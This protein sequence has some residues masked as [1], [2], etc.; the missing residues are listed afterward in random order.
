MH[1]CMRTSAV[2][3]L[4]LLCGCAG[5]GAPAVP[6]R[7]QTSTTAEQRE[8]V[9]AI[10][11]QADLGDVV[12]AMQALD[13]LRQKGVVEAERLRQDLLRQ[14]GRVG[15]LRREAEA[16]RTAP[17]ATV[18]DHYL[19]GR[20]SPPGAPMVDAFETAV[21]LD[22]TS[23][24]P[25]LGLAF[26]LRDV[27]PE[28]SLAIYERL[29]AGSDSQPVVAV[30]FAS[31]LRSAGKLKEALAVYERLAKGSGSEVGIGRLGMAQ[32]LFAL[33]GVQERAQAWASLLVALRERPHDPGVHALLRELLRAGIP[34][35]QLEQCLDVLRSDR[36]RWV[37]FARGAGVELL[38]AILPRLGQPQAA[39]LAIEN[40]GPDRDAPE[41]RR[42][43]RKLLLACG[44]A[45]GFQAALAAELPAEVLAS[46][47]N[48]V[49]GLW[50]TLLDTAPAGADP[51]ASPAA[52]APW[53]AALRDCGLLV[54]AE[55]A[56]GE[57]ERR[58]GD[59][60][61]RAV[62]A[63]VRKELAF[64][65]ALRR[66]LYRGYAQ[67]SASDLDAFLAEVRR[68]STELLGRDVVD[69]DVRFSVPMV[70]EMVDPFASGLALHLARYNRYFVVGRRAGGVPEG[71]LFT[72]L[73]VRDLP[74]DSG[75]PVVG[76]CREVLGIDR[77]VRSLSG[78]LG[79][80]LAGVALLNHYLV[81]HDAVVEWAQSIARKQSVARADGFA[82]LED[83]V[84]DETDELDP[85]DASHRLAA[86]ST[87][88]DIDLVA[89]VLDVIRLHE[90]RHLVDSFHYLP[91]EANLWRGVGLLLE[92]GLS[93]AAIEAE[94]ERRAELAALAFAR[95]PEV[96]LAHVAE[97]VS[98]ADEES[99]HVHGFTRLA[100]QMVG[101]LREEGV[102]Q[103]EAAVARWDR[104]DPEVVRRAARRLLRDLP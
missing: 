18:V 84:P 83:P 8:R 91:V 81:D 43:R 93:P 101:A 78:V 92:F 59:E 24:W 4:A 15:M 66:L 100:Q 87:M 68:L 16:R 73:S 48:Q 13:E 10:Q 56:V 41:L 67:Q 17:T 20:L 39:L 7:V 58:F 35:E 63:E 103:N 47:D 19:A 55:I 71:L 104:L 5:P 72:R 85:L 79:G 32:T 1:A 95:R 28:R 46:E 57:V 6:G 70:G 3:G 54:E 25:W 11:R 14:R 88:R 80:D 30:A 34:D 2:L 9:A 49:R 23:A 82:L 53:I 89:A 42:L 98:A 27:D 51:L 69:P 74:E 62:A 102:G 60:C 22:P 75:L 40:C 29:Y 50:R 99:P 86:V 94:M 97:F 21:A 36:E 96:V 52:A 37:A 33:G 45:K 76:R 90:R 44:D 77:S 61:I 38:A 65:N 26:A 64:E 31:A 12:G